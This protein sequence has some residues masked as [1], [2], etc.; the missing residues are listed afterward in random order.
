MVSVLQI[1]SL[2][3]PMMVAGQILPE[4]TGVRERVTK[5]LLRIAERQR[6]FTDM[7]RDR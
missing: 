5:K 3:S 2:L 4:L 7:S 1:L 6:C